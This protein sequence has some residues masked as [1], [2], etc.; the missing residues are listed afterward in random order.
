MKGETLEGDGCDG[1]QL[2]RLETREIW[3]E[4]WRVNL[5]ADT[6]WQLDKVIKLRELF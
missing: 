6:F 3:S 5:A 2:E 1:V 4:V